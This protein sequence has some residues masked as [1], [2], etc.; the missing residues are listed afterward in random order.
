MAW[1]QT[2]RLKHLL[3][4]DI[5]EETITRLA[6]GVIEEMDKTDFPTNKFAAALEMTKTNVY[7]AG[8]MVNDAMNS[9]YDWAD[10]NRVWIE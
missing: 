2:I 10:D 6:K 5:T 9:L 3:S 1:S 4:K 7:A 8:L